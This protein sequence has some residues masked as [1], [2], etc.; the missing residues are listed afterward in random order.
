[1][2]DL[3]GKVVVITGAASGIGRAMADAFSKEGARLVIADI[4]SE[5]L[6]LAEQELRGSG[7]EVIAVQTDVSKASSVAA[8]AE[9]ALGAFGAV[10][11]LCNNAG[12]APAPRPI[13]EVST[14]YWQWLLGTNLWGVIHGVQTFVPI[15]L[16]QGEEGHVVNTASVAGV[17][18]YPFPY[19]GVYSAAKHA[20]VSISENLSAELA[21]AQS[22]VKV[23]VLCPGFVRTRIMDSARHHPPDPGG[24][25]AANAEVEAAFRAAIDAGTEPSGV[26]E[27]VVAAIR[28][29]RLYVMT[30][31][32]F[33]DAIES[34]A[35]DLLLQRNPALPDMTVGR[36]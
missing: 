24:G 1:M 15:L 13:W 23:S 12:V 2:Q 35:Q 33:N 11:V 36:G 25:G 3:R 4:E 9:A 31:P 6:K 28:E 10:H 5:P 21:L 27:Q 8:L 30:H 22:K 7:A 34:H 20:V 14:E 26:A 19:I 32:S 16:R 17:L 29:E 18:S